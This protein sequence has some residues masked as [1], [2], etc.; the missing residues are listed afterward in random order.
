L[1]LS[2]A[3]VVL[4]GGGGG[5]GELVV[6][7]LRMAAF[8]AIAA[9]LG[10]ALMPRAAVQVNR[11]Q[12]S[13]GLLA[14]AVVF[15]FLYGWAAEILGGIAAI[16]GA[17]MVGLFMSHS[18]FKSRIEEGMQALAYG[19]F[20][21]VFFVNIGLSV[22]L[23]DLRGAIWFTL[24]ITVVAVLTKVAGSG[25]GARIGGFSWR[26]SIQLGV[27]MVSRGEVGLIIASVALSQ[28]YL[29][30][31]VGSAIVVMIVLVTILT[32][33][34]LRASFQQRRHTEQRT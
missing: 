5:A 14:L 27:G 1:F 24:A 22:N 6:I 29:E 13:R 8:L 30:P 18:P 2:L 33:P 26:E 31:Q 3:T 9:A 21:P 4:A 16:T 17:F 15:V 20:V 34:L 19:F 11:M 12:V 7:V 25:L 32:P 10:Y 28:G 23:R